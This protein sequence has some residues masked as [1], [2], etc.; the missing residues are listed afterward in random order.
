MLGYP[1][2][3]Y[4]YIIGYIRAGFFSRIGVPLTGSI[5][6]GAGLHYLIGLGLGVVF[7]ILASRVNGLRVDKAKHVMFSILFVEVISQPLLITAPIFIA[8]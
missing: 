8:S 3:S 2:D 4:F 7:G 5:L 6:L 1:G